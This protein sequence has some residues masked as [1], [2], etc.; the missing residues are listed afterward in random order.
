MKQRN[1][2]K[3]KHVRLLSAKRE[4]SVRGLKLLK[5][6]GARKKRT[7]SDVFERSENEKGDAERKKSERGGVASSRTP[8]V[9]ATVGVITI[10]VII[11]D[12][13]VVGTTVVMV[14]DMEVITDN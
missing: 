1:E 14:E 9:V 7:V 10:T 12:T 8:L 2:R 6:V 13:M 11:M 3:E 5:G 4:K